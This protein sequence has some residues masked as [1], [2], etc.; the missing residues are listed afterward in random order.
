MEYHLR[1]HFFAARRA[2]CDDDKRRRKA[3]AAKTNMDET[4]KDDTGADN[5]LEPGSSD[6]CLAAPDEVGCTR[7]PT[8]GGTAKVKEVCHDRLSWAAADVV[9]LAEPCQTS[10]RIALV[11]PPSASSEERSD[12]DP[13]GDKTIASNESWN[14]RST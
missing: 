1:S 11:M 6:A 9:Q 8:V 14:E 13:V 10:I 3:S 5:E 2:T 12:L 7:A 4:P